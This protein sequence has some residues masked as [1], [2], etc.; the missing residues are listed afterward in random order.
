MLTS[1]SGIILL[2]I[3]TKN[4]S[5]E[6]YGIWAQ[7]NVTI[8][9]IPGLAMLGLPYTMVRFLPTLK[10]EEEIQET[11]YSIFFLVL[12][13]S[14]ATSLLLYLFSEQIASRI[15][16]NN[17]L[18][19][20]IL[21]FIIFIECLNTLSI[22]YLRAR[23]QIKKYSSI[24][25]LNVTFQILTISSFVLMG[26]GILGATIGLLI[27][28][29][30][31]F[32]IT[33]CKV[34]S[35]I[36]I[37]KPLFTNIKE[38]LKFGIPTVTGNFSNWIVNSSDRYVIGILLGTASVG[39]YSPGYSLGSLIG[40]FLAPFSFLLPAILSRNYDENNIE[41]VKTILSYSFKYLMAISIPAVFGVSLLSKS[42]L[43]ILSTVEIA[44]KG[45]LIT[46]FVAMSTLLFGVYT[47]IFQVIVL[48]K[49]TVI[50]GRIWV[51]AALLNLGLNFAI[52]PYMGILG[53]ALTTLIAFVFSVVVTAYYAH[54]ILK[55]DMKPKF[56]VKSI[57]S[58]LIMSSIVIIFNPLRP[59]SIF[60]TVGICTIVYFLTLFLLNG[61]EEKELE[62]VKSLKLS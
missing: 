53:A 60:F 43:T 38:Y 52:I 32:S 6:D 41:E 55:F 1:L 46:P 13:T 40:I 21:S 54:R 5:I 48:E 49:K 44:S 35:E 23:E 27:T 2:P 11:F 24:A 10:K 17:T 25:F 33:T 19:V 14:G 18:I 39:Y 9:M 15:F 20:K 45:Y 58:S 51:I 56:L 16:D 42:I 22:N 31:L 26:K 29:V 37:R 62:F 30:I 28:T 36:G 47:I 8:G 4:L 61:F 59:T 34:I 3:L 12:F 50:V 57:F 7:I